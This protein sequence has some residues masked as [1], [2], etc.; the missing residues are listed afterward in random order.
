[1]EN[2][3]ARV[4]NEATNG[5]RPCKCTP[6]YARARDRPAGSSQRRGCDRARRASPSW[7]NNAPAEKNTPQR[8]GAEQGQGHVRR[9]DWEM[10]YAPRD[11]RAHCRRVTHERSRRGGPRPSV[12]LLNSRRMMQTELNVKSGVQFVRRGHLGVGGPTTPEPPLGK[13]TRRGPAHRNRSPAC[14][15]RESCGTL[16]DV[17]DEAV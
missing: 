9:T 11:Q 1:M 7:P 12:N 10:S 4:T 13:Q 15:A 3:R 2:A 17:D 14:A 5:L 16:L 6:G 8:H